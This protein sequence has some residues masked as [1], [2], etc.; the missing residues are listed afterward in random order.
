MICE[1]VIN[2]RKRSMVSWDIP[3]DE[4]LVELVSYLGANH[5]RYRLS[6][7][8][9]SD[10]T[11]L[12]LRSGVPGQE[13][14][15]FAG[16]PQ[17]MSILVRFAGAIILYLGVSWAEEG[18]LQNTVHFDA[19]RN[20]FRDFPWRISTEAFACAMFIAFTDLTEE[21]ISDAVLAQIPEGRFEIL[22]RLF[23]TSA[24]ASAPRIDKLRIPKVDTK[25]Y[26]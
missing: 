2:Q 24:I 8:F 13:D 17:E 3:I 12:Q 25:I 14:I 21:E 15:E 11:L 5:E 10:E 23:S 22:L 4:G 26:A 9:Q 7:V 16:P 19:E 18:Y 6:A 1:R 20:E